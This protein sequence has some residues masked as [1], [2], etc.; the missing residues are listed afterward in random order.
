MINLR[1]SLFCNDYVKGSSNLRFYNNYSIADRDIYENWFK[2][3]T[4]AMREMHCLEI[5]DS[6]FLHNYKHIS[7]KHYKIICAMDF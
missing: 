6:T 2:T 1:N 3:W 4:T 7:P 5:K